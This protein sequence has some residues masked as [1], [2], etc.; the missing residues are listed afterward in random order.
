MLKTM[1]DIKVGNKTLRKKIPKTARY[2]NKPNRTSR[3]KYHN[4]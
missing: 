2:E 4:H 3:N 1:K